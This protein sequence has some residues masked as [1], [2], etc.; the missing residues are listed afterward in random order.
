VST[1]GHLSHVRQKVYGEKLFVAKRAGTPMVR[2]S[3]LLRLQEKI[4]RARD[5]L[6]T[7]EVELRLSGR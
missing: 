6:K 5:L 4:T 7:W 1:S 3:F 2:P